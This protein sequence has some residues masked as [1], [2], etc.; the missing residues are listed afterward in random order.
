[1]NRLWHARVSLMKIN[2]KYSTVL[3]ALFMTLAMDFTMTLTM[4]ILMTGFDSGFPLRFSGGFLIGFIVGFPTSLIV[5][6]VVRRTV[7]K[8]ISSLN[9][10]V[11]L[12]H[13]HPKIKLKYQVLTLL[14]FN[15]FL[16]AYLR[17]P[18]FSHSYNL[19]PLFLSSLLLLLIITYT[20]P[21]RETN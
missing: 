17:L 8:M 1:M 19:P 13:Y 15:L 3:F 11:P 7:N 14:N 16:S 10:M 6:P 21:V 12:V 9:K 20:P 2:E 18:Y 5:I 4:T